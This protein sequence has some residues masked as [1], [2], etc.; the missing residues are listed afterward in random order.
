MCYSFALHG[1]ARCSVCGII[2]VCE[3]YVVV[4]SCVCVCMC[5]CVYVC[6][7]VCMHVCLKCMWYCMWSSEYQYNSF[8]GC[9]L[10][11]NIPQLYL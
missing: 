8:Y 7:C 9:A 6:V 5:M 2:Y 1:P 3:V 11:F 10:V 4:D